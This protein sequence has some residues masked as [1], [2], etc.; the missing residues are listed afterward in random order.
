MNFIHLVLSIALAGAASPTT[1]PATR[2]TN[3]KDVSADEFEKLWKEKKGTVLDVRTAKEFESG[4]IHGALNIDINAPDFDKKISDLDKSQTYL[5]HC[6][7][8]VRSL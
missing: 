1:Q 7:A 3:R 8:G 4:H 2:P 5:V 6:A